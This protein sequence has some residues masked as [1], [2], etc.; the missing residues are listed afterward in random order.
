MSGLIEKYK[1]LRTVIGSTERTRQVEAIFNGLPLAEQKRYVIEDAYAGKVVVFPDPDN[2][3]QVLEIV[4]G[5]NTDDY[6]GVLYHGHSIF[7][8]L[9][10]T[11]RARREIIECIEDMYDAPINA[12]R[13]KCKARNRA[14]G[15]R[16]FPTIA[17]YDLMVERARNLMRSH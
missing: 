14:C 4:L 5:A 11:Q 16:E 7:E 17:L 10:E 9:G 1:N 13:F 12:L 3:K 6:I 8:T 15:L 2:R